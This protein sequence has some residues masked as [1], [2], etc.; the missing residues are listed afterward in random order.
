VIQ[1]MSLTVSKS[2]YLVSQQLSDPFVMIEDYS[3]FYNAFF[4][5]FSKPL[6]WHHFSGDSGSGVS[7]RAILYVPSRL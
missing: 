5:D 2:G 6:A 3:L 4:K 1:R 7:F